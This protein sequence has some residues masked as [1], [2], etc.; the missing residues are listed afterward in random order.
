MQNLPRFQYFRKEGGGPYKCKIS[1]SL[2]GGGSKGVQVNKDN[3]IFMHFIFWRL[4][5]ED[6]VWF[7]QIVEFLLVLLMGKLD[8]MVLLNK[9]NLWLFYI[10]INVYESYLGI[11]DWRDKCLANCLQ[12]A[13]ISGSDTS[14]TSRSAVILMMTPVAC[15][16]LSSYDY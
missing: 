1:I 12:E 4:L 8:F 5:L 3:Y 6:W 13:D 11:H 14:H 2:L 9:S 7:R 15:H 16:F 10:I